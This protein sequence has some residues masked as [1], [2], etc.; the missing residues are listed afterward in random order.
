MV[1]TSKTKRIALMTYAMDNREA[2]GT[3]VYTRE[4][5]REFLA[6]KNPAYEFTLVHY[7]KIENDP[8]YAQA[9]EIIM[10]RVN[11]PFGS[12]FVSQLLFFWR[13]RHEPFDLIHWFQPRLYPFYWWAPASLKVVTVHGAGMVTFKQTFYWSNFV[14]NFI[15]KYFHQAVAAAIAD[16]H[17]AQEEI[18][19]AY[20]LK[21]EQVFVCYT[22][23][24]ENFQ[25]GNKEEARAFVK[26]K[27]GLTQPFF[28]NV[29]RLQPH[30]NIETLL[31]A[32]KRFTELKPEA[33]EEL[34]IIA[35]PTPHAPLLYSLAQSLNLKEKVHFID[36]VPVEDL[37]PFYTA[38]KFFIFPS[39][40]EGFGLPVIEA[41]AS[42]TAV[43]A[44]RASAL[45][46][47]VG[48]AGLLIDPLDFEAL[49]QALV[50]L[51]EEKSLE[52]DLIAKGLTRAQTFTWHKTAIKTLNIY[53]QLFQ[54]C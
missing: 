25:A 51:R 41:M 26:K 49:A 32:Y 1:E 44:S 20:H 16:S 31:R 4:L 34:V 2:K 48:E 47:V 19:K 18:I 36:Y 6:L 17:Q 42:G 14:F 46:E 33:A 10:P 28:L 52:T 37:N 22:G 23:G 50:R 40:D 7:Q 54:S 9:R 3:A 35:K 5:V 13:Y 11:L 12:H 38:A 30:K 53:E 24:G 27:Y 45:P 29:S 39:L 15:L 21:P 43:I 8:L